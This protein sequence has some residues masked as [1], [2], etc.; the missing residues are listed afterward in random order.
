[1]IISFDKRFNYCGSKYT[2]QHTP[3]QYTDCT[4]SCSK[5]DIRI[6]CSKIKTWLVQYCHSAPKL[7][8]SFFFLIFTQ[9]FNML[10][11]KWAW[12]PTCENQIIKPHMITA[13]KAAAQEGD[14][15][16]PPRICVVQSAVLNLSGSVTHHYTLETLKDLKD[17]EC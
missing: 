10:N 7:Q 4:G 14:F 17:P 11:T 13:I 8:G 1:M 9:R 5:C 2:H 15:I 12:F 16:A 6:W 3:H